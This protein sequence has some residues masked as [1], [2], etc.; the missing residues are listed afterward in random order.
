MVIDEDDSAI[1]VRFILGRN[2]AVLNVVGPHGSH[3]MRIKIEMVFFFCDSFLSFS[4]RQWHCS[5]S[6][7]Y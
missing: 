3:S 2:G 5:Y 4:A 6:A 7:Q 1:V